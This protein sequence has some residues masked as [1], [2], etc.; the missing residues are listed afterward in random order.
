MSFSSGANFGIDS[1]V[2][3]TYFSNRI[4]PDYETDPNKKI[5]PGFDVVEYC[6]NKFDAHIF[7][8]PHPDQSLSVSQLLAEAVRQKGIA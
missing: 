4:L 8:T 1:S 5:D 2:F 3:Y 6:N 7:V